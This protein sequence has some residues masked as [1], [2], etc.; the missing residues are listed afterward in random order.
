MVHQSSLTCRKVFVRKS[1]RCINTCPTECKQSLLAPGKPHAR[2]LARRLQCSCSPVLTENNVLSLHRNQPTQEIVEA[3]YIRRRCMRQRHVCGFEKQGNGGNI[4]KHVYID[5]GTRMELWNEVILAR[6]FVR[7][8]RCCFTDLPRHSNHEV[9]FMF[10]CFSQCACTFTRMCFCFANEM[11]RRKKAFAIVILLCC[12]VCN[13]FPNA[14]ATVVQSRKQQTFETPKIFTERKHCKSCQK[15][16]QIGINMNA[17]KI[18]NVTYS[19]SHC[20]SI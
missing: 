8:C 11:F 12:V 10:V 2:L 16:R 6:H 18:W 4:G 9:L 19:E 15:I 7:F 14:R 5:W 1:G 3:S 20:H 13:I 17:G